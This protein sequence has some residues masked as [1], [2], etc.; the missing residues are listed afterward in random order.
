MFNVSLNSFPIGAHI[1]DEND[2][3]SSTEY[4]YICFD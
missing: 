1:C 4:I 3:L 2:C